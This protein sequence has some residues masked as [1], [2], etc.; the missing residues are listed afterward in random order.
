MKLWAV[1]WDFRKTLLSA[2]TS[3]PCRGSRMLQRTHVWGHVVSQ[4]SQACRKTSGLNFWGKKGGIHT[5]QSRFCASENRE[6]AEAANVVFTWP[7]SSCWRGHLGESHPH[8]GDESLGG[9]VHPTYATVVPPWAG[10][11]LQSQRRSLWYLALLCQTKGH[12]AEGPPLWVP[13]WCRVQ[14]EVTIFRGELSKGFEHHLLRKRY[15]F[16]L[17]TSWLKLAFFPSNMTQGDDYRLMHRGAL[18]ILL[19]TP[20][21]GACLDLS[22]CIPAYT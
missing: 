11:A 4:N 6:E 8:H 17:I 12:H 20:R 18:Y 21:N 9:E 14:E 1:L 15:F 3:C 2:T 13:S 16:F 5:S 22:P 10:W 7:M 19:I